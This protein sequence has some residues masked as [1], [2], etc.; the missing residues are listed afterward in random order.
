MLCFV[1]VV[2][3]FDVIH[4]QFSIQRRG[5]LQFQRIYNNIQISSTFT[6]SRES[7]MTITLATEQINDATPHTSKEESESNPKT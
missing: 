2:C 3:H 6:A 4:S 5:K 7:N 1:L